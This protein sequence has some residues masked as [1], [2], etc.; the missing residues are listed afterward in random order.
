MIRNEKRHF[1][2]RELGEMSLCVLEKLLANARLC[3]AE[4]V[5]FYNSLPDEVDTKAALFQLV[6][7]GKRVLLPRVVGEHDMV[8]CDYRNASDLAL[9]A[10]GIMEPVGSEV[11]ITKIG[12]K[13][14]AVVPGMAFDRNGN[15]VGRG[16]GYYDT[17]LSAN[18]DVYRIGV[19]FPFQLLENVPMDAHDMRMDEVVA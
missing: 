9:G 11:D 5:F 6:D 3:E 2:E 16:K 12:G 4:T 17:F 18:K 15:R 13:K 8:W 1:T 7:R 10:Y 19:C 14:V